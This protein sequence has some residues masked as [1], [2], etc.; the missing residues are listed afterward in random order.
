MGTQAMTRDAIQ[1]LNDKRS[2]VDFVAA[3]LWGAEE[4]AKMIGVRLDYSEM[5]MAR[6]SSRL[7]S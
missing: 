1:R 4:V 5:P 6:A 7:H 2:K 3:A